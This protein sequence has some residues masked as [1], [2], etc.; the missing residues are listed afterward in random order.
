[1]YT[2]TNY[3]TKAELKRALANG[4]SITVWQRNDLFSANT[5]DGS[6]VIEGPHYPAAHTW[7]AQVTLKDGLVTSIK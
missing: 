1:M 5:K 7:G 3:K 6:A 4:D 2:T